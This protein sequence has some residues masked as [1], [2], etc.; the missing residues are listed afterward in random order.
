MFNKTF[1][2]KIFIF[3]FTFVIEVLMFYVFDY[4]NFGGRYL[5]PD[6][7]LSPVFGLMFGPAGSL[8]YACATFVSE[9]YWGAN[10]WASS[11]DSF[12]V[13]LMSIVSYKLWYLIPP[14]ESYTP[15]FNS[16]LNISKL[17]LVMFI[18]SIVYLLLF[19]ISLVAFPDIMGDLYTLV[20]F[21]GRFSYAF[22]IFDFALI[23]CLIFISLFNIFKI[24]LSVPKKFETKLNIPYKYFLILFIL[25]CCIVGGL[26]FYGDI[27][28]ESIWGYVCFA[29]FFITTFLFCIN[30]FD[31]GEVKIS[32]YY[33]IIEKIIVLFLIIIL[34]FSYGIYAELIDIVLDFPFVNHL[35]IRFPDL[36][37]K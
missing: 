8:G 35:N 28:S 26:P 5:I 27:I 9:N 12:V 36:L 10:F 4:M 24:P 25:A 7:A 16:L 23:Y 13:L 19:Q 29:L 34:I 32:N 17:L 11:I 30:T 6:L 3:I 18:V 15:K 14:K 33:S 1:K 31:V 21:T 20:S 2:N 22:N 37:V